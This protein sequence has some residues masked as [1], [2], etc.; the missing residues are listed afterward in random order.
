MECWDETFNGLERI[1]K[2]KAGPVRIT[3]EDALEDAEWHKGW[4]EA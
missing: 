1:W 4:R 3:K 2:E